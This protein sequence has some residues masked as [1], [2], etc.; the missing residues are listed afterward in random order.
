MLGVPST[1][2]C[3]PVEVGD[4]ASPLDGVGEVDVNATVA[5]A[6]TEAVYATIASTAIRAVGAIVALVAVAAPT[7]IPA[8]PA[9]VVAGIAT[10]EVVTVRTVTCLAGE[11]HVTDP[12]F[13][14]SEIA[15][16][17]TLFFLTAG[18]SFRP[19]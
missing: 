11:L 15:C 9:S 8:I 5:V 16:Y 4:V 14:G 3:Q 19:R 2:Q 18:A 17:H 12:S 7:A 6:A 1:A 10:G 13:D